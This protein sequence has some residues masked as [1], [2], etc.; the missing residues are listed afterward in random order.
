[1]KKRVLG[2]MLSI[3]VTIPVLSGC[4]GAQNSD[5]TEVVEVVNTDQGAV[6]NIYSW[7][8]EFQGIYGAY[9]SDLAQKHGVKVHFITNTSDSNSY[10]INLDEALAE[11]E[12]VIDDDRVDIF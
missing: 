8:S 7:N 4:G 10:Q 3:F 6:V 11:Q 9:A 12:S 5:G 2:V 1:M